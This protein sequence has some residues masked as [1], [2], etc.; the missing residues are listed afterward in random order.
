MRNR[1]TWRPPGRAPGIY[2]YVSRTYVSFVSPLG[3]ARSNV[4][5]EFDYAISNSAMSRVSQQHSTPLTQVRRAPRHFS[6]SDIADIRVSARTLFAEEHRRSASRPVREE[7]TELWGADALTQLQ[8]RTRAA[9][10]LQQLRDERR[11]WAP[12]T[13]VTEWDVAVAEL[14]EAALYR[15]TTEAE[16]E[17]ARAELREAPGFTQCVHAICTIGLAQAKHGRA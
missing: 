14:E 10:V 12:S 3:V 13:G 8:L 9:I 1:N 17:A 16:A 2:I 4:L 5:R 7:A 6:P 15:E 11:L